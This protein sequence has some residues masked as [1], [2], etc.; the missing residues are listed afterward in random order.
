MDEAIK[1]DVTTVKR[2]ETNDSTYLFL[3]FSFITI[4]CFFKTKINNLI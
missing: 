3:L 1:F 2:T 4:I